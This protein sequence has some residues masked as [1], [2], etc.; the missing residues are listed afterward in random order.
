MR[1]HMMRLLVVVDRYQDYVVMK[2][3]VGAFLAL[4]ITFVAYFFLRM[5]LFLYY[6]AQGIRP[7]RV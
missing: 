7:W 4:C 2:P 3:G 5:A 1:Y 6:V